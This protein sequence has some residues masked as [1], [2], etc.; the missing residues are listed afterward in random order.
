MPRVI[1]SGYI[2]DLRE[3]MERERSLSLFPGHVLSFTFFGE[4][5]FKP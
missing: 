1:L 5:N 4:E 2:L 3:E